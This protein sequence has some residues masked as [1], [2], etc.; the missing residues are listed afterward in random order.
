MLTV[1]GIM[2]TVLGIMLTVLEIIQRLC[3]MHIIIYY[4][5][6]FLKSYIQCDKKTKRTPQLLTKYYID[7]IDLILF[8]G[9]FTHSWR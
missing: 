7:I 3:S 9:G 6:P 2:L 5:H 4:A 1:L 8:P